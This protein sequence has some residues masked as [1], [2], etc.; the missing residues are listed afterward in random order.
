VISLTP[1][2]EITKRSY[3]K[4]ASQ[5]AP[6]HMTPRFW[7]KEMDKFKELLPQGK[8]LEVGAGGGRDARA[9]IKAG[10]DYVGTDISGPLLA[11][12]KKNVPGAQFEQVSLYDLDFP[13]KFDGFWCAA[14]L[15]H[16]PKKYISKALKAIK[17]NLKSGAIGFIAIKEGDEEKMEND[18][19]DHGGGRFF[20]YW[21]NDEFKDVLESNGLDVL[22]EGYVPI[23]ERTKWLT[24]HVKVRE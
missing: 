21:Q 1:E 22:K 4:F 12:A 6:R 18:P 11:E 15:L 9:L 24:Y 10:Y 2:E 16:I 19:D 17:R 14:V 23:S 20:A 13:Y 8:V 7:G 5:W 3:D